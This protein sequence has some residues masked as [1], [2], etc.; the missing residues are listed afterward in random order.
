MFRVDGI[1][2]TI[3]LN[4]GD[5][6]AVH[7][8]TSDAGAVQI[9]TGGAV[10]GENDVAVLSVRDRGGQ[11]VIRKVMTA[12]NGGFS[13]IFLTK[14]TEYLRVGMYFWKVRFVINP[15]YDA[16]GDIANW[17]QNFST[18]PMLMHLMP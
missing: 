8:G 6:G 2:K 5:T 10:F 9:D 7:I 1:A 15:Y 12:E 11:E 16:N 13:A 14:D 3:R 17:D 4:K 18:N